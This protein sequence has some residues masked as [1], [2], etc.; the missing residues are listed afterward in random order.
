MSIEKAKEVSK[1]FNYVEYKEKLEELK[2]LLE[3]YRL[4]GKN[5]ELYNKYYKKGIL[6]EKLQR[7]LEE[8]QIKLIIK[9][10][11]RNK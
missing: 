1:K 10:V 2:K 6:E 4:I 9:Y 7:T 11:E 3:T 8:E 5:I